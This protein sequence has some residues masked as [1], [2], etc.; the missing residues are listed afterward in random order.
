MAEH[1]EQ[2]KRVEETYGPNYCRQRYPEAYR[3]G[4]AKLMDRLRIPW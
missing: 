1:P 2:R 4:F 3:S